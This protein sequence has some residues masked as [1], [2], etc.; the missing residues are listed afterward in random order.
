M[1]RNGDRGRVPLARV[2]GPSSHGRLVRREA[3][4]EQLSRARNDGVVLVCAPAGSGK[5]MLVRSWLEDSGVSEHTAW[6]AVEQRERDAQHFWLAVTNALAAAL[7]GSVEPLG[8]TPGFR[9]EAVVE[10][11]LEDLRLL[12]EPLVLVIDDLHELQSPEALGWLELF[13]T[14]RPAGLRIVLTSRSEPHLNLHRLRLAGELTEIRE[15]ELRFSAREAAELLRAS[16][17][18]LS[19][20][21]VALLLER[22]EGWAAGLRLAAISLAGHPD[23][24]RFVRDFSGSERSVAGYLMA[25]VLESQPPEVRELLLRTSILDRVTGRLADAMTGHSDSERILLELEEANAFVTSLDIDRTWFRYHHLFADFLRLELRRSDPASIDALHGV[26]ARWYEEHGH[27]AEAIRHAQEAADW[28]YAT[29]LLADSY[30]SLILDGRLETVAGCWRDFLRRRRERTLS[31]RSCS[32]PRACLRGDPTR[33]RR[34]SRWPSG[35]R[36]PFPR[37]DAGASTCG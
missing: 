36:R 20:E 34:T 26:A 11:L 29:R 25:E 1:D 15:A 35:S 14:R 18:E 12:E 6:V 4:F 16:E 10:R 30:I 23:P 24:E 21:T 17:I 28:T 5:T 33:P 31:L 8:P 3:L 2:R 7:G 19:D 22:T 37:G 13:I 9:G 27:P 32:P